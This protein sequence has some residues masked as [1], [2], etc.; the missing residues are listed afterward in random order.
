MTGFPYRRFQEHLLRNG[1]DR[2]AYTLYLY[3]VA[4]DHYALNPT[5]VTLWD[6][7]WKGWR[8]KVEI[9]EDVARKVIE[10]AYEVLDKLENY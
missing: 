4:A 7:P 2:E 8:V 10:S 5:T 3:R 9:N 6:Q 1:L